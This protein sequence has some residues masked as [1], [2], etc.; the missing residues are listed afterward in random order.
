MLYTEVDDR[1]DKLA[2]D[3]RKYCQLGSTNDGPVYYTQHGL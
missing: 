3:R 1:C 2:V